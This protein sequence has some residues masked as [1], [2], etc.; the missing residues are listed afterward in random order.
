[1]Y[2]VYLSQD[3][4]HSL[5]SNRGHHLL[6]S[7][8]A[9]QTRA[10]ARTHL[11]NSRPGGVIS[12]TDIYADAT[13]A[14][15]ALSVALGDR[16]EWFWGKPKPGLFDAEVFAYCH[17]ILKAMPQEAALRS[18]LC[19]WRNLVEFERRVREEWFPQAPPLETP[20]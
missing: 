10:A 6:S 5:P 12:A 1:M 9:H 18:C 7:L 8:Q 16:D 4:K 3:G 13:S 15:S 11:L 14:F 2:A 17:L 19:K 20:P